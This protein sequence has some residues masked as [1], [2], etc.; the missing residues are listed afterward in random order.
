MSAASRQVLVAEHCCQANIV[1]LFPR[2]SR[3]RAVPEA[4]SSD[5]VERA[6]RSAPGTKNAS[7]KVSNSR[8]GIVT[9]IVLPASGPRLN[10]TVSATARTIGHFC[11]V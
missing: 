7:M 1:P 11:S 5:S 9:T 8:N 3:I 2:G 4:S 10:S 6:R